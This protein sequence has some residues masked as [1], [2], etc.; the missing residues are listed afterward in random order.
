MT[1][2]EQYKKLLR[3][4]F[5]T[6]LDCLHFCALGCEPERRDEHRECERFK[7]FDKN[8]FFGSR[9]EEE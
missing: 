8:K 9:G 7:L 6:C 1:D 3:S 5:L 4:G 2:F